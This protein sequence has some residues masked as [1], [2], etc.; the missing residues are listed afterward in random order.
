MAMVCLS[1]MSQE[2]QNLRDIF[3]ECREMI[4]VFRSSEQ[5]MLEGL[6]ISQFVQS[7]AA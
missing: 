6:L 1:V 5:F 4:E 7:L 3:V 2:A